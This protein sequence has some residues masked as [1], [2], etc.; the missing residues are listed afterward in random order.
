[1]PSIGAD[2]AWWREHL[3]GRG[4]DP[5]N[6]MGDEDFNR[7]VWQTAGTPREVIDEDGVLREVY[8][9]KSEQDAHDLRGLVTGDK[10]PVLSELDRYLADDPL[11]T[12]YA[13]RRR[14]AAKALAVWLQGRNHDN[15]ATVSRYEA[16]LYTEY[17]ATTCKSG[18]TAGGLILA[19]SAY[20]GWMVRKG[21]AR[22]NPWKGQGTRRRA[23]LKSGEK[24]P[25]TDEE[26][27]QL[28]AG[29][30]YSTLH[31]FMRIASLSGMRINEIGS[32]KVRDC[33]DG[34]FRIRKAKT[35][36][37]V[38]MVPIHDAL[39]PIIA[40]RLTGKAADDFLIEEL[41]T[42]KDHPGD[43]AGKVSERFT[44]YRRGLGLDEREE[45]QTQSNI[46]FHSFRRWFITKAEQ[47]GQPPH[48]IA[49]TV[50][51][52]RE[53]MTLGTY[54]AGPS[55]DQMREVVLSVRLPK[56]TVA[57]RPG[58]VRMGDGRWGGEGRKG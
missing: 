27:G 7:A 5:A 45:G 49:S 52:V 13:S 19:L 20:W 22:E 3:T 57:D 4:V 41:K 21:V 12:R 25:F 23:S 58:G 53:G 31:D 56:G 44:T 14:R 11:S 50:G 38:R 51:H 16:G 30:T 26:V 54:S 42:R 10:V 37:G 36:A 15:V 29:E 43:R 9:P 32:L 24:R 2:A 46:D 1:M 6:A 35:S 39:L 47:A 17:L 18:A 55:R 34:V 48:I 40:R 33:S 8:D 28:L